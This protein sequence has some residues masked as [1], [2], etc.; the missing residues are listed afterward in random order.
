MGAR[1]RIRRAGARGRGV[2]LLELLVVLG[3]L[4]LAAGVVLP[5]LARARGGEESDRVRE[6]VV[7][8]VRHAQVEA[9]KRGAPVSVVFDAS[10]GVLEA[11][12]ERF[13]APRGWR[14]WIV[15]EGGAQGAW[16]LV[17]E[18]MGRVA[19][20]TWSPGRLASAC[21]ARLTGPGRREVVVMGD[22]I[23]GVRVSQ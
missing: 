11:G 15:P 3:I 17:K 23:D 12:E 14:V 21:A 1:V 8:L 20:V 9:T 18:E 2:T 6:R 4:A 7:G 10:R 13:E 19:L 22:A 5:A 16:R